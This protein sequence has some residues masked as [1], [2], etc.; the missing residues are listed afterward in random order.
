MKFYNTATKQVEKFAPLNDNLVNIYSCGPTVYDR[1]H[2]GNFSAYIYWDILIRTLELNDYKVKRVINLTD[3]G[4]LTSDADD[5]EDKLAKKAN[6]ERITAWDIAEKYIE[7]FKQDFENL[8]LKQPDFFPRATN[9]ITQQLEIIKKL[10]QLGYTYQ[11]DDGIYYDTAKFANYGKMARL[12]LEALKAGARVEFN[13]QKRNIT[14]FALWKFSGDQKRDMEWLT[15]NEILDQPTDQ[16]L[17]GF[18]GW[19]LECSTMAYYLLG[20]Q[21]DIHTGGID[22]IQIHHTN[23]IAQIEPITGKTFAQFWLHNNHLKI[24]GTKVSKSLGN[25]YN[26]DQ[27]AER[28]FSPIDFKMFVL[29]SHYQT[30]G[31]FTFNLLEKAQTRLKNWKNIACLRHQI[32][33]GITK[34]ED[35]TVNFLVGT[36]K[37]LELAGDNLNTPQILAVIDQELSKMTSN[38]TNYANINLQSFEDFLQQIDNLLGFDLIDSTPDISE[39]DKMLIQKRVFAKQDKDYQTAD[40]IRDQLKAKGIELNDSSTRSYWYYS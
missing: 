24:D 5:G 20:E 4:H 32:H 35:K 29:Q 31:N 25:T 6:L 27:L 17:M 13:Q 26:L 37:I 11:I 8:K 36:H 30:E 39:Q 22:H 34:D 18:P 14:D 1:Q 21:L 23:E 16:Q 3:V 40:Q 10:K 7:L 19:H 38:E 33:D 12:D 15:P 28:G 9:F 2:I